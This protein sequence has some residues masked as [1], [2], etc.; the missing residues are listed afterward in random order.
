MDLNI[1]EI[2]YHITKHFTKTWQG[3]GLKGQVAGLGSRR[4]EYNRFQYCRRA[5]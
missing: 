5:E 1:E 4:A 2:V 3:T